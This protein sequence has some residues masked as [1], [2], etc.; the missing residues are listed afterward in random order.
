MQLARSQGVPGPSSS[1][2]GPL[3]RVL[4]VVDDELLLARRL[5]RGLRATIPRRLVAQTIEQADELLGREPI[6]A[7]VVDQHLGEGRLGS[8]LL[9]RI[10]LAY[11][12][13]RRVLLSDGL[14]SGHR[15]AQVTLR[16]PVSVDDILDAL[17]RK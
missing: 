3:P 6:E 17:A 15:A 10:A 16:K 5:A 7:V 12:R 11:P 14:K 8:E 4:L 9:A 1:A 13:V 2:Q